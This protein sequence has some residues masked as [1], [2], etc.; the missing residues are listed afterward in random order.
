MTAARIATEEMLIALRAI[1]RINR[2]H[3]R[4]SLRESFD[5][6]PAARVVL[7]PALSASGS[8]Q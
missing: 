8:S 5:A 3:L 1:Q 6:G 7:P 4:R 2:I